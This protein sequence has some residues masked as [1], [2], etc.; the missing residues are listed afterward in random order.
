MNE[1]I[2]KTEQTATPEADSGNIMQGIQDMIGDL[3]KN[4]VDKVQKTEINNKLG[5]TPTNENDTGIPAPQMDITE[6]KNFVLVMQ[7]FID[8]VNI[9]IAQLETG[10][11]G[12]G[13]TDDKFLEGYMATAD[14][15][16]EIA[17]FSMKDSLTGL[18][19]RYGF[20]N[21]L[22]LEWNRA[23]RDKSNLSLV[24]FSVDGI[25]ESEDPTVRDGVLKAVSETLVSSIKRTTDFIA[26]WSDDEF[27]ALLPITNAD[28]ASIVTK[29]I[30]TEIGNMDI[31][32]IT[33]IDG[34]IPISIGACVHT[35]EP[36]EKPIDFIN[37]A[38][39]A[40]KKAKETSGSS[41]VFA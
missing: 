34:N 6:V 11:S 15:V 40:F 18:S 32:G 28:G 24:I 20:D 41:V 38:Y 19:N 5:D 30:N 31:S 23:T 26:R 17:A 10:S 12:A 8:N 37:K 25:N 3:L 4:A 39:D 21:R 36:N 1:Q 35:P 16:L 22:I 13:D 9:V 29:R 7:K 33:K 14:N 2:N 27:A